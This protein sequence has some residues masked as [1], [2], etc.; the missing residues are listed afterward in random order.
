MHRKR[1]DVP[2]TQWAADC[3]FDSAE[4]HIWR[5]SRTIPEE[6]FLAGLMDGPRGAHEVADLER[7][8]VVTATMKRLHGT[9]GGIAHSQVE[10]LLIAHKPA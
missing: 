6:A 7:A 8:K 5:Y 1:F 2:P 10:A 9:E 3:G 4:Y